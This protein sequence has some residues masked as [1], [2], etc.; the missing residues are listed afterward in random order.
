MSNN[1]KY[2][3]LEIDGLKYKTHFTTKFANRKKWEKPD[4]GAVINF[5]PG[6]IISINVKEGD[7]VNEG[8]VLCILEAMK[9]RN[10]MLAPIQG[11]VSG[12][13]VKKGDKLPKNTLMFEIK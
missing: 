8:D 3:K 9:M 6:T 1:I 5:I 13:H 2:D 7:E 10:K 12:I 4:P 11:K